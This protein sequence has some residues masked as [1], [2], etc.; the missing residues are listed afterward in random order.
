[1][2]TLIQFL[3]SNPLLLFFIVIGFGFLLGSIRVA[4]FSLG[5]SAV[6]FTGIIVG[7]LD[8][9]L[10]VPDFLYVIGLI[11]FVYTIG[12]QS[13]PTFFS[14]FGRRALR[15]NLLAAGAICAGAVIVLAASWLGMFN[16][17]LAAGV[18]AGSLT[19]TPALAASIESVKHAV[20]THPGQANGSAL[21]NAPVIGYS[22]SYPFGVVGVLLGFYIFGRRLKTS[23]GHSSDVRS[24]DEGSGPVVA[25]TYIVSNPETVGVEVSELLSRIENKGILLSRVRRGEAT[26]LV[27]GETVL[28][29][30]DYVVVVASEE[31]H[32][33]ARKLFGTDSTR[34]IQ[35]ETADLDFR[36]IEVSSPGVVGRRIADLQLQDLLDAT[37]TRIRR[38]DTDFVPSGNTILE[39]GD[40]VRILTWKGNVER[41]CRFF[42]DSVKT[43]SEADFL[44]LSIGL[45]AGILLGMVPVPLPGG[46]TFTLGFAGGPLIVGLFLGWIRRTGPVIWGMPYGVNL[47]LR[48]LGLVLFLA[49]IGLRAGD[50]F[51]QTVLGGGWELILVGGVV[52]LT[53]TITALGVGTRVLGLPIAAA[54][55]LMSGIQT[56]PACL[57]YANERTTSNAANVW[58]ASVYPL[59]MITKIVIAQLIAGLML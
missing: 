51:I 36:R 46:S 59:S 3:A 41:L 22:V 40:R 16:G 25:R 54:M 45:V 48:Q 50:G 49:G 39:R 47:T 9:R 14:S 21:L 42:G 32:A 10:K 12:L 44:S 56:Q 31:G 55:G 24:G 6:L 26:S 58:Y 57:A 38:G 28:A 8:P 18:F 27:Y 34:E 1:M 17:P 15:A 33:Q 37:I 35:Y 7:A 5:P 30:G 53:V 20:A 43:A 11:L 19:N 23:P 52:T 4:G 2:D 29:K 13:G